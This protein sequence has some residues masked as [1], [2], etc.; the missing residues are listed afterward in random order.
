MGI[1]WPHRPWTPLT[2]NFL[3][4]IN[5]LPTVQPSTASARMDIDYTGHATGGVQANN[6]AGF[7]GRKVARLPSSSRTGALPLRQTR[8]IPSTSSSSSAPSVPRQYVATRKAIAP[9]A[10]N[11][12]TTASTNR[13]AAVNT[14]AVPLPPVKMSETARTRLREQRQAASTSRKE[15]DKTRAR[16]RQARAVE[17]V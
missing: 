4:P 1:P 2:L 16:A 11:S 9:R 6:N 5:H 13:V 3:P 10:T 12:A 15:E 14:R 7:A 17:R 8:D